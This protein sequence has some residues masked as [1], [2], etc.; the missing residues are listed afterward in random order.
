MLLA[1]IAEHWER[2]GAPDWEHL[3]GEVVNNQA[4]EIRGGS[5]RQTDR[6]VDG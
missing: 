5:L 4:G 1:G 2:C 6:W 3:T